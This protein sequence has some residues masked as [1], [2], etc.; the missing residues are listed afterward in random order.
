MTPDTIPDRV[1]LSVEAA[2]HELEAITQ[3]M[4]DISRTLEPGFWWE[5]GRS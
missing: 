4:D 2:Q 3:L 1:I 5:D